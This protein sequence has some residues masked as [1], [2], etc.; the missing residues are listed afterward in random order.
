V[1]NCI[2][3][4]QLDTLLPKDQLHQELQRSSPLFR[5]R[6]FAE[7]DSPTRF[8]PT[9]KFDRG[10]HDYDTSDKSRVP[11]WC[12]RLLYRSAGVQP[13][14]KVDGQQKP[15]AQESSPG[16][17]CLEYRSW[18]EVTISDHRPVS[19][20]YEFQAKRI[21]W[22]LREA[23]KQQEAEAWKETR[24]MLVQEALAYYTQPR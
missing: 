18:P 22:D 6:G 12:D 10:T 7:A 5:L 9:Y 11:A 20:I 16:V 14:E 4:G 19:A 17:R 2:H 21:D 3:A 8:A 15:K 13:D 23:V 24:A 1:I